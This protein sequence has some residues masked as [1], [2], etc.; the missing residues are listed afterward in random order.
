MASSPLRSKSKYHARSVS[1]PTRLHPLSPHIDENL[2]LNGLSN[3]FDHLL[4]LLPHTQQAF[5]RQQHEPWVKE[6]LNK[7]L[8]LLDICA[9]AKDMSTQTK[10]DVQ[11]LLSIFRRRRDTNE[12][13][14]Y[15]TSRKK[16]KKEIQKSLK[17]LK[18]IKSKT[19]ANAFDKNHGIL[20]I[21]RWLND[22]EDTAIGVLEYVLSYMA[23]TKD[24]RQ[25]GDC[26]NLVWLPP[27]LFYLIVELLIAQSW[28]KWET[29]VEDIS[30]LIPS[31]RLWCSITHQ[32]S[33][34]W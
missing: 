20:E 10:L 32:W 14:G 5:A 26:R 29:L 17:D 30:G 27:D 16:T 28:S 12:F 15:L 4:L 18:R 33:I 1:E 31:W 7:Y 21:L 34:C 9:V 6:V 11:N 25:G 19:S 23:G 13:F 24:G 3:M 8:R 22:V 2:R